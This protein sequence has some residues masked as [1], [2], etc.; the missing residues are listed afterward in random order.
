MEPVRC[1]ISVVAPLYNEEE[2]VRELHTRLTKVLSA[3]GR[4]YEIIFVDDGSVD[5]TFQI[6][7]SIAAEDPRLTIVRLRRNFGQTAGLAAGFDRAGGRIVIA[8]DGDLQHFPEDIPLLLA[9]IDEGYEV[10]SGWRKKRVDNFWM[11]RFP[12]KIANWLMA[13]L[14]GVKLHDFG[15]VFKAY[16]REVI[17]DL[18]LYGELHRFIPAL[19]S[20][21]GVS[22]V[23][24]PIQNVVR[25][26]GKSNYG[27]SRTFRVL[28]DLLTVKFMISYIARPL[29]FFGFIGV[30]LFVIGFA[31]A[32]IVTILYY[33][34]NLVIAEHLGN[35][36][37]S[38][39]SMVLGIQ[40]VA[41]GLSLEVST[42]TY[43]TTHGRRIYAV[44]CAYR[45]GKEIEGEEY[46]TPAKLHA[47]I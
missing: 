22:I 15:A 39:L 19:V 9:K 30:I 42:R 12:S 43:H 26:R 13:K 18:D 33:F 24:V 14:S 34:S 38:M 6:A 8:M 11:R 32:F 25:E 27:I 4:T 47:A 28:M 16:R 44:R 35:L 1:D 17:E 45:G 40:L 7:K 10:A 31:V 2:N 5:A 21:K 46:K 36:M 3:T 20:W 23:E 37:F 29:H 41:L